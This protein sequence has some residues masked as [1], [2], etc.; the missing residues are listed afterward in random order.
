VA[1]RFQH[2]GY[3]WAI[4]AGFPP[5]GSREKDLLFS[6]ALRDAHPPLKDLTQHE[7]ASWIVA[8]LN[9]LTSGALS[10]EGKEFA[11][12]TNE[13]GYKI[14]LANRADSTVAHGAVVFGASR[15]Y[16]ASV[17]LG[18]DDFQSVLIGLLVDAPDD[19]AICEITVREPET[20][21]RRAYG[22]NGHSLLN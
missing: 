2:G 7:L 21:R 15:T 6:E 5:A 14:R 9:F 12:D 1:L 10:L 19:L 20:S 3:R 18:V 11:D 4:R 16:F 13:F 8:R 22:W 17:D